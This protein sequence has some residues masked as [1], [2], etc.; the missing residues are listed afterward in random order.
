MT[1]GLH[2]A[3]TKE[4]E[5]LLLECEEPDRLEWIGS[6]LEERY[7]RPWTCDSDKA[8]DAIHRAFNDSVLDYEVRTPLAGVILG[9]EPLYSE[10]DYIISFKSSHLV[11][12]VA[13]ALEV[14]TE[15]KFREAYFQIDP[16]QYGFP[17]T[18]EDFEYS[19]A[20][21]QELQDFYKHA[22][23]NK[24]SVIFTAAQ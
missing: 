7:E 19:W 3:L 21:V 8:W 4:D 22:S 12:Q 16:E 24:R 2:F 14:V 6:V 23:K 11:E 13:Q 10:T 17:T 9:G 20:S 5:N 15:A 1:L 18:Q